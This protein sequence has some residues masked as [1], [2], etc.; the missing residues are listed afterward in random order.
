MVTDEKTNLSK[1]V[2]TCTNP[3]TA[4]PGIRNKSL[5]SDLEAVA[6]TFPARCMRFVAIARLDLQHSRGPDLLSAVFGI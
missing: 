4:D 1:N 3:N 2:N 6:A 5:N